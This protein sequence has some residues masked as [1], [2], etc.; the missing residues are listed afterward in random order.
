MTHTEFEEFEGLIH[1]LMYDGKE[2]FVIQSDP[3]Q[4]RFRNLTGRRVEISING[5]L[6]SHMT[7]MRKLP[8]GRVQI[9]DDPKFQFVNG[10]TLIIDIGQ[11]VLV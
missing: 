4:I 7:N 1:S 9:I 5:T 11:Y 3:I 6:V 2:S 10:D 8:D